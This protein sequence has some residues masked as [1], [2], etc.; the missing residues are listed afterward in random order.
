[1]A[2]LR[3]NVERLKAECEDEQLNNQGLRERIRFGEEEAQIQRQQILE[4]TLK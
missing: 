2:I 3:A 4:Y 1:M